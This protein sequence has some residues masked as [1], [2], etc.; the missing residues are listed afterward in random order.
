M[1]AKANSQ[2]P[3][4]PKLSPFYANH[5]LTTSHLTKNDLKRLYTLTDQFKYEHQQGTL[6]PY[7]HQKILATLF[8]EP[9]TR[10]RLSF[11]TA[12]CRL[13]GQVIT[14]E[15]AL[16]TS[17]E[18]GER[19]ED[20]GQV[21]GDYA[22]I[23]VMRH[24]TPYSVKAV[25]KSS[26]VPVIN[27]GDGAN[28]HPTQA[29]LDMYTIWKEK[30]SLDGLTI[31]L[32]GDLTYGRTIHS[33]FPL[34]SL[35]DVRLVGVS[36][37]TLALPG[38]IK[39]ACQKKGLK[40]QEVE[41]LEEVIGDLDVIYMTRVQKERFKVAKTYEAYK[42]RYILNK[43]LMQ[44][45]KPDVSILHPLPR[46]NEIARELDKDPRAAYFKQSKNGVYVRMAL[47]YLILNNT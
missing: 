5:L 41:T 1:K 27:A 18:K 13:G 35:F 37:P 9:S 31:G 10:T 29:L 23:I 14:V 7:L 47:L 2:S 30:E 46:I 38:N 28:E 32:V 40:Y 43:A 15:Q 33:L 45:A 25:S 8:F 20:M 16:S 4:E 3:T 42:D 19:L 24:A 36:H 21:I 22:D 34:L 39:E 6:S 26:P 17:L 11:E 44:K 12:M